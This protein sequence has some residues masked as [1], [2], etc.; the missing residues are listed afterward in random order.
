M[1]VSS[2]VVQLSGESSGFLT[3]LRQIINKIARKDKGDE[4]VLC[5]VC[6]DGDFS[7][8]TSLPASFELS[9]V[10]FVPQGKLCLIYDTSGSGK[11]SLLAALLGEMELVEGRFYIAEDP[12]VD[13]KTSL[14]QT[15]AYC[16]QLPSLQHASITANIFFGRPFEK[17]RYET[18]LDATALRPDLGILDGEKTEIG[19]NGVCL[20][21][22]Q[23]ARV[24]LAR[25]L[26]SRTA[27]LLLDDPLSA[28][29]AHTAARLVK[30]CLS[31]PLTK[32]RTAVLITHHA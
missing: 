26:Y 8:D 29:D 21:G 30:E 9:H 14:C 2:L 25:T 15:I 10:S 6:A 20:S 24:A 22:G 31:G 23:Q 32:G 1:A 3:L 28:V 7:C 17:R 27:T 18:V 4:Q 11:S 12:L 13:P 16:A 5:S 19:E